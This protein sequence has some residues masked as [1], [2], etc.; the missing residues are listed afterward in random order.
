[1]QLICGVTQFD[2]V[3]FGCVLLRRANCS[4]LAG[5]LVRLRDGLLG[6]SRHGATE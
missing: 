1:M 5:R 6:I 3:N 2:Q 4:G